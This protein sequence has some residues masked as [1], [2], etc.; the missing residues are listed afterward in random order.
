MMRALLLAVVALAACAQPQG[1]AEPG[2]PETS[3]PSALA[4]QIRADLQ[5][6]DTELRPPGVVAA[7]IGETADLG[8]GLSVRPIAVIEDSRCPGDVTCVWA[9][10][11][12]VRVAIAGVAG[13]SELTLGEALATPRGA[14]VLAVAKPSP[15]QG[16]PTAEIGARPAYRFGFR[17]Q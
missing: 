3:P 7:G 12:R 8:D 6:L 2:R 10:R 9:G 17:R 11:L 16:W 15:W 13:D 5:R 4:I 1:G 14:V